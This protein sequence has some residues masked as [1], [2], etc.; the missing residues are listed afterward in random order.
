MTK[1]WYSPLVLAA[2][3]G[4][5][6]ACEEKTSSDAK[7][8]SSAKADS[9]APHGAGIDKNI[10]E[11]V[12]EVAGGTAPGS[13]NGPP[14]S[15]VFAPG[16]ADK[17]IRAGDP[18]KIA[19]GG[20]G[21]GATVRFGAAGPPK[22]K[23]DAKV[24]VAVQMG[25]RSAM[26]TVEVSFSMEAP[27]APPAEGAEKPLV[28]DT[29]L[30]VSGVKLP[31]DQPGE[32]PPGLDKQIGKLRGS[33]VHFDFGANGGG[34]L[35]GMEIAKDADAG[36]I[37]VLS[38]AADTLS[39]AFSPYPAEPVGAGAFW[40]VTTRETFLGL[41][42]VTYRMMKLQKVDGDRAVVAVT[43]KHYVVSGELGFPG[44]PHHKV[45]EFNET[46]NG[47][48]MV[49]VAQPS[50]AQG[51]KTEALLANLAP[52]GQDVPQGLPPG[53]ALPIHFELK[54]K[55]AAGGG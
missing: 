37:P 13:P 4:A 24:L 49:P 16:A 42:M 45:V 1:V 33:R 55:F 50:F 23:F 3:V 47:S 32:L 7:P 30:R 53:Q 17:E 35:T 10:A 52:S 31:A 2:V 21:D 20:K 27:A 9:G 38:T 11:A 46:G 18:P 36:L 48:V 26:P 40:M 22:K 29:V 6:P 43:T 34:R 51:E 41:D 19:L 25:P 14:E 12:A 44:L 54:T 28:A 15:G 5:A 39:L 8:A